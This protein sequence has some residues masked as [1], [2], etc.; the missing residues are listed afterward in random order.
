MQAKQWDAS[1][2]IDQSDRAQYL[3]YGGAK[4]G[5]KSYLGRGKLV[6]QCLRY[7]GIQAVII[8]KTFPELLAN[9]IR[10]LFVEYPF[11]NA[12]YRAGEKAIYFP[13]GSVLELK[14]LANTQDVYNYQGIEYDIIFL[15]EATQHEE[16]TFKILKTSLRSDPK[17]IARNPGF[18]PFFLLTGNPGGIGHSWVKRLFIER[19]FNPN[20]KAEDYHFIQAKIYDNP[21]FLTANPSYLDNL[22]DLDHDRMRAYLEG[23]WEVF[24]GQYFKEFRTDIHIVEPFPIPEDWNKIFSLDWGY[25]PHPYHCGWYA[26]DPETK[27]IYKYRE[28]EGH[29]TPPGELA[30]RIVE[31]SIGDKLLL[32]VGDTQMWQQNP[33]QSKADLSTKQEVFTDKSIALQINEVLI[34]NLGISMFQANKDRVT[35]WVNLKSLMKWEGEVTAKGRI[36]EKEP[37]YRIFS[38]CYQTIACYPNMIHSELRP[39]DM[40]KID[41]DDP[42]DSDRYAIMAITDKKIPDVVNYI[43]KEKPITHWRD[44]LKQQ[45]ERQGYM[46]EEEEVDPLLKVKTLY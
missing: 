41:G 18:K 42:V 13:N 6:E 1:E 7:R 26:I 10:K 35:G 3:L 45:Y 8:R 5:G 15:D 40:E 17:I 31:K 33:F 30:E 37:K 14:H 44:K 24:V 21:I 19:D 29:E 27:E 9:H 25:F 38:T 11:L 16:E 28:M 20:E 2:Y 12:W 46:F 36:L 39:E 43:E 4:G 23:D 22:R 34:T 32:G